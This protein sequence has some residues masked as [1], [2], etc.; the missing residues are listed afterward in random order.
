MVSSLM[1][2]KLRKDYDLVLCANYKTQ[3]NELRVRLL[4]CRLKTFIIRRNSLKQTVINLR[5]DFDIM[6][7][8][9]EFAST[10]IGE[11][12]NHTEMLGT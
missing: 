10:R 2:Q 8:V 7:A 12:R 11:A 5:R 9:C 3:L 6:K 4:H 1:S